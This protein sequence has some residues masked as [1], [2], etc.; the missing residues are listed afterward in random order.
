MLYMMLGIA[1]G[2]ALPVQASLNAR[3]A[4]ALGSAMWVSLWNYV[5]GCLVIGGYLLVAKSPVPTLAGLTRAPVAAWIGGATGILYMA[6]SVVLTPKLGAA[7]TFGLV[8]VG[9]LALSLVIDHFGLFGLDTH[10]A[11]LFRGVGLALVLGGL[12]MFQ[13]S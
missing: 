7:L 5:I 4:P 10:R 1:A 3:L 6:F 13:R 11:N 8:V 12:W 2:M 9:Q